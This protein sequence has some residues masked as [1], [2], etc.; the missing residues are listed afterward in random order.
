MSMMYTRTFTFVGEPGKKVAAEYAG[1]VIGSTY[2][3]RYSRHDNGIVSI[4]LDHLSGK[5]QPL[6][7]KAADFEKWWRRA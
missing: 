5:R 6:V 7:V 2:Q 4:E 1:F 3:L